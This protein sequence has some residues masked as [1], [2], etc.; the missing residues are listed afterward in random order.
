M[1][2]EILFRWVAVF[3]VE[4]AVCGFVFRFVRH[5]KPLVRWLVCILQ[6]GAVAVLP[7]FVT[8]RWEEAV[9]P[10]IPLLMMVAVDLA[11]S[12]IEGFLWFFRKYRGPWRVAHA[13]GQNAWIPMVL[14]AG[15]F[16]AYGL[17]NA[18]H[19]VQTEYTVTSAKLQNTYTVLF[20]SDMHGEQA[21]FPQVTDEAIER[22]N[23]LKPDIVILGG[24][25]V[26]ENASLQQMQDTLARFG[27]IQARYGKAFIYGNHDDAPAEGRAFTNEQ[28]EE[29]IARNGFTVLREGYVTVGD[30]LLL[31]GREDDSH[32]NDTRRDNI[33]LNADG[34]FV[35]TADHQPYAWREN[36]QFGTDLQL[37]GHT[38]GGQIFPTG[39]VHEYRGYRQYG[40]YDVDGKPLIVSSG[41]GTGTQP[42]RTE[43]HC[44][45]MVVRLVPA[46]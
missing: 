23:A 13:L 8:T 9:M 34:R 16:F 44:E 24:D 29:E 46:A 39:L 25:M 36:M 37:S 18:Q 21:Q 38:H 15:A 41:I 10:L 33:E 2:K 26:D 19:I 27:R 3:V 28:L 35:L 11:V 6:A 32:S 42:F 5:R 4:A 30:D 31:V 20:V 14:I 22:M 45:Y 40:Q 12:L 7:F 43:H 17:W 1:T